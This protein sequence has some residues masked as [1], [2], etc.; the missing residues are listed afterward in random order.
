MR[1]DVSRNDVVNNTDSLTL[2][3]VCIEKEEDNNNKNKKLAANETSS[4]Q[5]HQ[6]GVFHAPNGNWKKFVGSMRPLHLQE[7]DDEDD[8]SPPAPLPPLPPSFPS[9]LLFYEE[10]TSPGASPTPS[11]L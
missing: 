1:E 3:A 6:G 4:L 7:A 9:T 2:G 11:Y 10:I 5:P 8:Q